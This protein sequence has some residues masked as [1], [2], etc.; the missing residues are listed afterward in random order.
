MMKLTK[1]QKE[2]LGDDLTSPWGGVRLICDGYRIALVVERVK[3]MLFRVVTYIN[4]QWRGEWCLGTKE[5]PEQKFLNK[6]THRVHSPAFVKEME[7]ILGKRAVAKDPEYRKTFHT[8]D[9]TC[10]SGKAAINHLCRVCD[11][12]EIDPETEVQP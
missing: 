9:I 2:K 8:Y 1:E 10:P 6:K 3:P 4:G 7:K 5:F 11:S 12:V